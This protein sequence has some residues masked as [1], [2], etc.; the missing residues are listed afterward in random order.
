MG[1]DC[2]RGS[3]R[4]GDFMVLNEKTLLYM[5]FKNLSLNLSL[6]LTEYFSNFI[7]FS[8]FLS[9]DLITQKQYITCPADYASV[10]SSH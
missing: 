5:L 4:N 6:T 10:I 8:K 2:D 7:A 1:F 9:T 3:R